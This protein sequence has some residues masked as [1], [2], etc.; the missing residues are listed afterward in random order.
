LVK[1]LSEISV[2]AIARIVKDVDSDIRVG[3]EAKQEIIRN[4]E[5]YTKRLVELA[6]SLA[7][8]ANRS[9]ILI[10]DIDEAKRQLIKGFAFH[11]GL[12]P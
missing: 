11:Q 10:Q 1:K 8:N 2:A 9:T 3:K 12:M 6:I 7:K 4:T 5:E